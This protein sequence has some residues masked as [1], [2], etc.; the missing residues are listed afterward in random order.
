MEPNFGTKRTTCSFEETREQYTFPFLGNEDSKKLGGLGSGSGSGTMNNWSKTTP[1]LLV[2]R[3]DFFFRSQA[4]DEICRS[5]S[6]IRAQ[7]GTG[8]ADAEVA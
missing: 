2:N 6:R 4:E 3:I 1:N 8:G 7:G 5:Q